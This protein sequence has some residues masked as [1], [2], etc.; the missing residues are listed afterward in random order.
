MDHFISLFHNQNLSFWEAILNMSCG[1]FNIQ[2]GTKIII[3][4]FLV[5]LVSDHSILK[6]SKKAEQTNKSMLTLKFSRKRRS[7]S[8]SWISLELK[9]FALQKTSKI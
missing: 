1:D 3:G 6:S 8:R 2:A 4:D 7:Q 9:T 5:C